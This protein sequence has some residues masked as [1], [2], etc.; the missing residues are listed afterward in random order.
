MLIGLLFRRVV[1]LGDLDVI[2]HR[3]KKKNFGDGTGLKVEIQFHD[4]K[5]EILTL[6][7]PKIAVGEAFM[8]G[9]LTVNRGSL[10]DFL[11]ICMT[12]IEE[13]EAH[14]LISKL[15]GLA[16][17]GRYIKALNPIRRSRKNVAH[18][19]D[20]SGE[21]YDLFLDEDRQYSCAYFTSPD[22]SLEQ[23]QLNKKNHV[24][25]K[26]FLNR[27]DLKVLDIGSG[28]GGLGL[29]L[30]QKA[31]AEVTGLTLSSEQYVVSNERAKQTGFEKRVRFHLEDYR[32][33][34]GNYDRIV[35]VGMFE[36]VGPLHYKTFFEKVRDLL[37]DD[38]VMLL[39]SIGHSNPP[40]PTNPWITKYIFPGG[41][42]P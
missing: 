35:S 17:L 13:L 30:A 14:P 4:L 2:D 26:L 24:A 29:H 34:K 42:L 39:H 10:L 20:L 40:G 18:H 38:G 5:T 25:N 23:A 22:Q 36:H 28:W 27:P 12:N 3:G 31:E 41:Y 33:A 15:E 37:K 9:R 16:R 32:Q 11:M 21:L 19:Y 7:N 6:F 1:K 8:D